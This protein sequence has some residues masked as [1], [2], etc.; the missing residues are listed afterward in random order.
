MKGDYHPEQCDS[1]E[2]QDH[3]GPLVTSNRLSAAWHHVSRAFH[4]LDV[5]GSLRRTRKPWKR[6]GHDVG[7]SFSDGLF[8]E[9]SVD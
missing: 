6:V 3:S 4:A 2:D 7:R 9:F 1:Y 5:L 8:V